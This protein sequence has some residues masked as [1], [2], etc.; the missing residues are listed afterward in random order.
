MIRNNK[1]TTNV[2]N[3]SQVSIFVTFLSQKKN[4]NFY[5]N[6][7]NQSYKERE[8]PNNPHTI[9]SHRDYLITLQALGYSIHIKELTQ[10]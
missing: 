1:L 10:K 8:L 4:I 6:S 3:L 7:I 5:D 2:I 9:G